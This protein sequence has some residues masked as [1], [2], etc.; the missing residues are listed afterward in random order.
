M[1][2]N[3]NEDIREIS[4]PEDVVKILHERGKMI[5]LKEAEEI[6]AFLHR[7]EELTHNVPPGLKPEYWN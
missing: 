5:S 1:K 7:A 3:D 4:K 2:L 6:L